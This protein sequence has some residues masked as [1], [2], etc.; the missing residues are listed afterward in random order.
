MMIPKPTHKRTSGRNPI[1]RELLDEA[2]LRDNGQCQICSMQGVYHHPHH[3]VFGGTG[4]KRIHRIENLITLCNGCHLLVHS[5]KDMREWTYV[6]SRQRYGDVV[7]KLLE[8]KW[9]D[10]KESKL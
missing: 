2:W 6:W 8:Q 3:I 1:P 7:D 4:R 10:K 5:S 9:S